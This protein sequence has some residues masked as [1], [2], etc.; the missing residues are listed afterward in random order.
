VDQPLEGAVNAAVPTRAAVQVSLSRD[1]SL[2]QE[3]CR[4]GSVPRRAT[5]RLRY[6]P[7]C[8]RRR[9][10]TCAHRGL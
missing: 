1:R 9:R 2:R 8:P 10:Q 6:G 7:A 4:A 3:G 5:A